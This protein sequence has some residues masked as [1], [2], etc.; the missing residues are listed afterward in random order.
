LQSNAT[1]IVWGSCGGA[2]GVTSAGGT[3][4]RVAK[5]SAAQAIVDSTIT[6]DGTNVSL[7]GDLTIQGGALTAGTTSQIGDLILHDGN[8]QTTTLRSGNPTSSFVLTLPSADSTGIQC[9]KSDGAG[10][11]SFSNCNNGTGSGGDQT[12]QDAYDDGNTITTSNSRNIAFN[13]ADTAAD[14]NFIV[15]ILGTGNIFEVRDSGSAALTVADGGTV[16][17]GNA[18]QVNGSF[19]ADGSVSLG[20][21]AADTI[22]IF[23]TILGATPLTFEGATSNTFQTSFFITDPTADRTITVPNADGTICLTSGNCAGL[24]GNGDILQNGNSFTATMTIGTNDAQ[25]LVLETQGSPR[26]TIDSAGAATFAGSLTVNGLVTANTDVDLTLADTENLNIAN[27]VSGSNSVNV[28]YLSVT[29]S[30]SSGTQRGLVVQNLASTGT[31]ESL[32]SLDNIDT[33]TAVTDAISVTSSGGG[34]T[35]ILNTPSL[36]ISGTGAITGAT[37]ISSSGSI[38]FSGLSTAGIVTNTAGGALGTVT[39]VPIANGG[40]N[41]NSSQGAINNISQL[42][43]NGDLLYNNGTNSTRLARGTNG[44]CLTSDATTILWASCGSGVTTVGAFSGSSQA[45]GATI[46]TTTITFGPAD[47]TNP[48]MVSTGAQTFGGNKTIQG[49]LTVQTATATQDQI[50]LSAAAVGAARFAATITNADLTAARTFTLPDAGGTFAVS[51]SGNI[52]LSAA[53]NITLTGQVPIANGGTGA[54]TSQGAIDAISQL[55]T[56]GDILFRNATNSTRLARGTNGQCLTSNATTIV[57]SACGIAAEADTL[58][59]VTGRGAT[60]STASS[61]T[62]GATIRG[63][64]VDTATATQD[65][66]L[67]TAAATGAARFD[68]TVTNADLTTARTYTLPDASGTFAISASGNI[69]LSAAGNITLTGQVPIANG[70]TG[71]STSQG[72]ID[73]I[74][75]L[76]TE[77]DLLFRN[78]TN[79]TRLARGTNGQCLQS[80]ATTLVW[81]SCG[82]GISTVGA[83]SASSQANGATI[84]GSTIT[85]GPADATNPG[86]VSTA[87]QTFLG[88]KTFTSSTSGQLTVQSIGSVR[89][90][91]NIN[92]VNSGDQSVIYFDNAGSNKFQIGKQGDLSFFMYDAAFSRDFLRE[93]I[94]G[95]LLLQ[96]VGGGVSIGTV[97]VGVAKLSIDTDP[98]ENLIGLNVQQEDTTNNNMAVQVV[99]AGTGLSVRIND[100]GTTT[101]ATPFIIDASGNVGIGAATAGY[102]LDVQGGDINTS[103]VYRVGGVAGASTTCSGGQFLQN[104]VVSGGITTGGTCAAVGGSGVTTVGAFSGSS[105]TNGATIASTTITFGPADTTNPGMVSTGAQT[106]GGNKTVQGTITAQT[107]TATQD[108]IVLSAAA[109]GAARFAG[110]ITN[111]DLT[112][113]RTFTLP[114]AGGTFA[115]SASGNIA[116]SAAGN[117]TLTGQVP[118]ANGG[119]GASTSQGA[120]DAISQ[121]TT[122]GDLLFRN[123]TNSTRLARG[124]NGQCLQSNTTTL[125]W[126]SCGIASEADTLATVTGR[127][128]TTATASSFTGGATIRGLTVDTATAT[129]DRILVTAA[130]VGAARFDGS[131]TNADLTAA[132]TYTLPDASGTFAIGASGN[133]ALSATGNLTVTGQIPVANGGT[134]ASTSQGAIN[135]ISQLTTNGDLLYHNGTNS[136]RLARG[137]TGQCL[138][139]NATTIVWGACSAGVTTV[140]T[141]SA[142]SQANGATISGSTITFGPADATNPGMVSTGSQTWAGAKTFN[143]LVTTSAGLNVSG[144]P[145]NIYGGAGQGQLYINADRTLRSTSVVFNTKNSANSGGVHWQIWSDADGQV[146]GNRQWS[147]WGYPER[148]TDGGTY[149]FERFFTASFPTANDTT[150]TKL[151]QF[152]ATTFVNGTL[153]V[154]TSGPGSELHVVGAS[155]IS[156]GSG[157]LV[158]E[159]TSGTANLWNFDNSG[160][161]LRVFRENYASSGGGG[162]GSVKLQITDAGDLT[163]FGLGGMLTGASGTAAGDNVG[164][165]INNSGAGTGAG[166]YR[167]SMVNF[168]AG[169]TTQWSVGNDINGANTNDFFIYNSGIGTALMVDKATSYVT[170]GDNVSTSPLAVR[171]QVAGSCSI[172]LTSTAAGANLGCIYEFGSGGG[173]LVL[174]N[175]ANSAYNVGLYAE[176][177]GYLLNNLAIGQS[178]VNNTYKLYVTDS[179]A[180]NWIARLD[181]TSTANT[182]DGLLINLGVANA[183]RTTGNDFISFAGAAIVDGTIQGGAGTVAYATSG[184]DYAEYYE[185]DPSNKPNPGEIVRMNTVNGHGVVRANSSSPGTIVGVVSTAP[186]FIG[187]GP[188]CPV[189][190]LTECRNNYDNYNALVSMVGQVPVKVNASNGPINVGDPITISSTDGIGAKAIG[191]GQIVGY[192][193]ESLASGSG[194]INV[195][196]R[197]E[198]YDPTDGSNIQALSVITD[199][200]QADTGTIGDLNVSGV[201]TI[202][203]LTVTGS[204][205]IQGNLKVAGDIETRDITVNGHIITA[206]DTPQVSVLAA[207]GANALATVDGN[208]TAGSITITT[209]VPAQP[210]NPAIVGPA[211]GDL[212]ELTFSKSYNKAPRI[213]ITGDDGTS[214]TLNVF[215]GFKDTQRFRISTANLPNPQTNYHFTYYI[216]E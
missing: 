148:T 216:V 73:A 47:T 27:V 66:I 194:T 152:D 151:L 54:S 165:T 17:A 77:G 71:A 122:E 38:T 166:Q 36:D 106:F 168:Q 31:T 44:Q 141:F 149:G 158:I 127:G 21:A 163:M 190:S 80:N 58:A 76:T 154:G 83:F 195:L 6:D 123:A 85:F 191:A 105:Q 70:G 16:T 176:S 204:A 23:G 24:G 198:W 11:L 30:S 110:T 128:A 55:T 196:I 202:T 210:G 177:N 164:F 90:Q 175:A 156:G 39:L 213:I 117:I 118:I 162:G 159:P 103:G 136:T 205:T 79:S 153:G 108:Q 214:V 160:G 134:G 7:T 42:T 43:T 199:A 10:T 193:E 126:G 34:F 35:N 93:T 187:N 115:V 84:A 201:A 124:S 206:G 183:S 170:I 75:Q 138:T 45:N 203:N 99:N 2:T 69:A 52:A 146:I 26:L 143:G 132:R 89:A 209:G 174:R 19:T 97:T 184:A 40:T 64:T 215:P 62:G 145:I 133:I 140:G 192:A 120:I 139:S 173:A 181:N 12:L 157:R 142:S 107:S 178:A 144:A 94:A 91:I 180:S 37:G 211:A 9:L 116:L 101:D 72:A 92:S 53:G 96:P 102:K 135:A 18:L 182:A 15:D 119:T 179:Q 172:Q 63:L 185:I 20:N 57:W 125:V 86:M 32:L 186:G 113:A 65:R 100:D 33:D 60:T 8:G 88:T 68:G 98:G 3:T 5:F 25:S 49:T 74:S 171:S 189:D 137:T 131:I 207:A 188:S 200:L 82:A 212:I 51:A 13:L 29:N 197:T 59:T 61:F 48:G 121:L 147:L 150:F 81:G 161:T 22:N 129:Q 109:V 50:V 95:D 41:A 28:E 114:D 169:G 111:A 14:S 1:T 130:A 167:K 104:Q 56:E 208:D 87:A 67:V 112:A 155:R 4:N 78:A 46:S